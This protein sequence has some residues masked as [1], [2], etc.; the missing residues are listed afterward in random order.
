MKDTVVGDIMV[1]GRMFDHP[2]G[3]GKGR[4]LQVCQGG[5]PVEN[6]TTNEMKPHTVRYSVAFF[7]W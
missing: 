6:I 7:V 3:G 2:G 4:L 1:A 5:V